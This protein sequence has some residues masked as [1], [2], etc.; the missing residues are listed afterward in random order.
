MNATKLVLEALAA[1]QPMSAEELQAATGLPMPRVYNAMVVLR[2][3]GHQL[4]EPQ[5]YVATEGGLEWLAAVARQKEAKEKMAA[6]KKALAAARPKKIGRRPLPEEVREARY[7]ARV[8]R[9]SERRTLARMQARAEKDA[10]EA[11]RIA[12]LADE[13]VRQGRASRTPLEMAWGAPA[14]A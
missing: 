5:R 1:G 12:G 6:E 14:C 13:S 11:E 3:R 4:A 10:I 8:R 9:N 7:R 2:R